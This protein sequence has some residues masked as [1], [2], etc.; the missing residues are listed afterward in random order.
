MPEQHGSN[1]D[2]RICGEH[3]HS[4]QEVERHNRDEHSQ[5]AGGIGGPIRSSGNSSSSNG[6]GGHGT[7]G[8]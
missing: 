8:R 3:F 4:Q 2:C 6:V 7:D 5:Q 1:F